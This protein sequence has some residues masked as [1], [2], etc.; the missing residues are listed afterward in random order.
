MNIEAQALLE[1]VYR[2]SLDIRML[3]YEGESNGLTAK[4]SEKIADL[5]H[6]IHNIPS[7]VSTG[8]VD[9]LEFHLNILQAYD[10]KY[11][12]EGRLG[13]FALY[14]KFVKDNNPKT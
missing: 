3:G 12:H 8:I 5:A 6:A 7:A 1:V 13:Y 10:E 2:I 4:Q 14:Q 9:N 11:V